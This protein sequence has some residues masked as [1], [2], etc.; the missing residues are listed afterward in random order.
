MIT[1]AAVPLEGT[2]SVTVMRHVLF[3]LYPATYE[4]GICIQRS[5]AA[6]VRSSQSFK[7]PEMHVL[8]LECSRTSTCISGPLKDWDED[9]E[10]NT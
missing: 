7:G 9:E 8:V 4:Q 5:T 6:C 3:L 1:T 2:Q 10:Y